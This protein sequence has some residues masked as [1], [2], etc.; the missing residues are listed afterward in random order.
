MR[1]RPYCHR[2]PSYLP[3]A[4]SSPLSFVDVSIVKWHRIECRRRRPLLLYQIPHYY[5]VEHRLLGQRSAIL[6][7]CVVCCYFAGDDGRIEYIYISGW[8]WWWPSPR[9]TAKKRTVCVYI[10]TTYISHCDILPIRSLPDEDGR[11]VVVV[12]VEEKK[13]KSTHN[14]SFRCRQH[15]FA[16]ARLRLWTLLCVCVRWDCAAMLNQNLTSTIR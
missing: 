10:P 8:S 4:W 14:T 12:V 7:R 6:I 3:L 13:N 11:A 5:C 2:L 15:Q 9:Q 1:V 16:L